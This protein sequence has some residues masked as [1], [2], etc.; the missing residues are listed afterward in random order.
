MIKIENEVMNEKENTKSFELS[1]NSEEIEK[2][3]NQIEQKLAKDIE[4]KGF[5]KGKAPIE[6]ARKHLN[7]EKVVNQTIDKLSSD[8]YDWIIDQYF[9][10]DAS[11]KQDINFFIERPKANL[12]EFTSNL[13]KIK[14][15]FYLFPSVKVNWDKLKINIV[16]QEVKQEDVQRKIDHAL[17]NNATLEPKGENAIIEKGDDVVFD[18]EGS[19]NG[20]KFDGGS[21]KNYELVI[22]SG[23]FIPGFEDQMIGMKE[24]EEKDI[25]VKF[26]D[27]YAA[28]KLAGKDAVFHVK[29]HA[30]KKVI[31]AKLDDEFV[32]SLNIKDVSTVEELKSFYKKELEEQ[33]ERTYEDDVNKE[34]SELLIE[35][36]D[37]S[38]LPEFLV[39]DQEDRMHN[40]LIS[41]LKQY[42]VK[43]E[44]YLKMT[45]STEEDM[46]KNFHIESE[47]RIKLDIAINEISKEK[48]ITPSKEEVQAELDRLEKEYNPE[49]KKEMTERIN[50]QAPVI[51]ASIIQ[52]MVYK[53]LFDELTKK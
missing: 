45:N 38:Y 52:K 50:A 6:E 41:M 13:A 46:K 3:R 4:I 8:G 36:T 35:N 33:N 25:N 48:G 17:E 31:N 5:R 29:I 34:I 12:V 9:N 49:H 26:P 28:N 24:D 53:Y 22:G 37:I 43:L 11:P 42:N 23:A 7:Q 1:F 2:A 14:Y 19:I 20:E 44:D 40:E 39:K 21:A 10:D 15:D 47:K 16:K 51:S 27:D 30:I 32:K 18:F